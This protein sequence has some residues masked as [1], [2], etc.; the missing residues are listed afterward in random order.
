MKKTRIQKIKESAPAEAVEHITCSYCG[1][2][3]APDDP[4]LI[5]PE[6]GRDGCAE[7]IPAGRGCICPE[8][9]GA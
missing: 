6:C 5:C 1:A 8:C 7:C 2:L 3:M 4:R 9:E